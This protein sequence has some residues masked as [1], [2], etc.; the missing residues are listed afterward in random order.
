MWL[1]E[2]ELWDESTIVSLETMRNKITPYTE[3]NWGNRANAL[4][5]THIS[6][7]LL[8]LPSMLSPELSVFPT[9][10]Y[11]SALMTGFQIVE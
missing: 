8:G 6:L 9:D 5:S 2:T 3:L 1:Q 10:S 11:K 7:F 4:S